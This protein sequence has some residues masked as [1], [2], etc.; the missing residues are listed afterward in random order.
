MQNGGK[1]KSV[2]FIQNRC[3][4]LQYFAVM[5]YDYNELLIPPLQRIGV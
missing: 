3:P 4:A 1:N 2:T 5:V